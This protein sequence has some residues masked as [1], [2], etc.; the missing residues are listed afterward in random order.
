[1]R[2]VFEREGIEFGRGLSFFD[3]IFGFAITVLVVSLDPPPAKSWTSLTALLD[4]GLGNQ[5]TCFAISFVVIAV[6][7]RS[8]TQL[9]GR[10]RAMDSTL[11]ISNLVTVAFV[12]LLPFSTQGISDPELYGMP[13]PTALY[14]V[15]VALAIL[16]QSVTAEIARARGL[17]ID[18]VPRSAWWAARIDVFAKI[19]VFL[20]SVPV[21]FVF[22]SHWAQLS[23]LSLI[24]IGQLTGRWS[25]R[26]AQDAEAASDPGSAAPPDNRPPG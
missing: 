8:N 16:S 7:W 1:M 10:F 3:A 19:A 11:I 15:N 21:A 14:A 26:V 25:E 20:A 2:R 18:D 17:L 13:L 24:V 6:F 22:G 9:L 23:W 12:V 5:L 4:S